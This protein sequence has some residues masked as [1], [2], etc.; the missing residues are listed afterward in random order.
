MGIMAEDYRVGNCGSASGTAYSCFS[1]SLQLSIVS[2]SCDD[3]LLSGS[4]AHR[5]AIKAIP[6]SPVLDAVAYKF[7]NVH[8][9]YSDNIVVVFTTH[10]QGVP[11]VSKLFSH[12]P[13]GHC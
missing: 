3:V 1:P 4:L 7:R 9:S 10:G 12:L 13:T 8:T 11:I 2:V 5:I 6:K